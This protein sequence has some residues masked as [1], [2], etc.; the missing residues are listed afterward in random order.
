MGWSPS[1]SDITINESV[2]SSEIGS[3]FGTGL[4]TLQ[5]HKLYKTNSYINVSGKKYVL[6][7][8]FRFT[9]LPPFMYPIATSLLNHARSDSSVNEGFSP[10]FMYSSMSCVSQVH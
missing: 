8:C 2:I 6:F 7:F 10:S 5:H 1:S 4:I 9:F 3:V